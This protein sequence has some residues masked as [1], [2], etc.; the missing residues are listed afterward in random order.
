[1]GFRPEGKV[2]ISTTELGDT[3]INRVYLCE[4]DFK[5]VAVKK[6]TTLYLHWLMHT[7]HQCNS[8]QPPK[9]LYHFRIVSKFR[10]GYF[11]TLPKN[12]SQ[13]NWHTLLLMISVIIRLQ[14]WRSLHRCKDK[15]TLMLTFGRMTIAGSLL[16]QLPCSRN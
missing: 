10:M 2:I 15:F 3:A 1:M 5:M 8:C 7:T 13:T 12:H 9:S 4:M 16:W 11:R 6:L 14:I